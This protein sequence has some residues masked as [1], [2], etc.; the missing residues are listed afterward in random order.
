MPRSGR[1]KPFSLEDRRAMII[2]VTMPLLLEHGNGVT[3]KQIADNAGV[4]E[5][6]VFRAFGDRE[7]LIDAAVERSLDP[8]PLRIMLR[9]IDFDF[10]LR[11]RVRDVLFHLQARTTGLVGLMAALH[12]RQP[13]RRGSADEIIDLIDLIDLIESV[14]APDAADRRVDA[15]TIANYRRLL[16]FTTSVPAFNEPHPFTIDELTGFVVNGIRGKDIP[17]RSRCCAPTC[18]P[19]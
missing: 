17:C 15:R 14:L 18:G 5:V 10:P 7:S 19:T 3:T 16:A 2:D 1:A 13:P 4:E 8:E 11:G 6:T 9:A 12:P